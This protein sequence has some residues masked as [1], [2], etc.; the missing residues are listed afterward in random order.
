MIQL[1]QPPEP[2]E[3]PKAQE[4]LDW[5]T[6]APKSLLLAAL[7]ACATLMGAMV[8]EIR[9]YWT[10]DRQRVEKWLADAPS[11]YVAGLNV[12]LTGVESEVKAI[13]ELK[14]S[15]DNLNVTV[16]KLSGQVELLTARL[17]LK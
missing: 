7:F 17:P 10:E 12:R 16:A 4:P 1:V 6:V 9:G 5:R 14:K 13:P 11:A 2:A 8:N 3:K 15:V